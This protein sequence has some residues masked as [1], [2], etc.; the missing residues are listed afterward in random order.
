MQSILVRQTQPLVSDLQ[1]WVSEFLPFLT[2]HEL[3]L[4]SLS[5][6]RLSFHTLP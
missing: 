1:I 3:P 6:E 5:L 4:L 2:A